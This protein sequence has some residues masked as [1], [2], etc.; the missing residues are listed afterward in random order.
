MRKKGAYAIGAAVLF[1]SLS[2]AVPAL[3]QT[4][5]LTMLDTLNPG[6]WTVRFRDGSASRKIC[7]KNG[8]ELIQLRH[9]QPNCNRFVVNDDASLVTV[10]YTCAGDGYGRTNIRRETSGLVQ[11]EGQGI[12][13]GQPFEFLAEARRTGNC[14]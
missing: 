14:K 9:A 1:S 2:L 12:A 7:V 4:G 5:A 10:Q 3:S 8:R 11:I 6:E 13:K